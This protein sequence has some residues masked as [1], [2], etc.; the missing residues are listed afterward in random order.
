M[1]FIILLTLILLPF[2]LFSQDVYSKANLGFGVG[3]DY[4]GFGGRFTGMP[5]K[6]FGIFGSLGYAIAGVGVN[7]GIQ[8][9]FNPKGRATGYVTGMY[10]Y[11]AA[12]AVKNS[13]ST[14]SYA[15]KK[16][17]FGPSF[18]LGLKLASRRNES[19]WWNFEFL[20][21]IRDSA[22][23]KDM[24]DFKSQGVKMTNVPP[25]AVSFG[26]HINF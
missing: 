12:L 6:N 20:L 8:G 15:F 11:N 25:F 24:D 4:G 7:G 10:G 9:I 16:L 17:Y 18:G 1:K 23:Q 14:S 26:Y 13:V 19:N 2:H 22:F 3:L 21:P 5:S